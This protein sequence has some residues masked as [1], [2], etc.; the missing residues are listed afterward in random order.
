MK[1]YFFYGILVLL[2]SNCS[3]VEKHNAFIDSDLTIKQQ[4]KDIDYLEKKLK[5]IQPNLYA[6]LSKDALQRKF[7]SVRKTITI[8]LKPNEFYFKVFPLLNSVKQ[9]HNSVTNLSKRY[10]KKEVKEMKKKG[11]GPMSQF[12]LRWKDERLFVMKNNSKDSTLKK[13][14]EVL[15][16]DK[17]T[18]QDLFKKY[19][20][21]MTSDGFNTTWI[22][23]L[24]SKRLGGFYFNELGLRDSLSYV[25]KEKDSVFKKMIVR[26]AKE[27]KK[28]TIQNDSIQN[29]SLKMKKVLTKL[30]KK[31]AKKKRKAENKYKYNYGYDATTKDYSKVL[32]FTDIDSCSAVFKIKN[33]SKGSYK[34]AYKEVF[35]LLRTTD[36]KNLILDLRDNP[37]GRLD[38]IHKLYS[39]LTPNP[40]YQLIENARLTS[41]LSLLK[42]NYLKGMPK[43]FYLVTVPTYPIYAGIALLKTKKDDEG[44][45]FRMKSSKEKPNDPFHFKGKTYVMINGGSFSASCIL[46]SK[47]KQNTDIIFVG[48]ETGG[49]F[50]G[51]VAGRTALQELP[52]SKLNVRLW[53]MEIAAT[54]KTEVIGRGI[55]PDK[56]IIPTLEDVLNDNDPELEWIKADIESKKLPSKKPL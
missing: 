46:S 41:K 32:T 6:Y 40:T 13:G 20:Q 23:Y 31:A 21:N 55:F 54:N 36:T 34:V 1:N 18:P 25:F 11:K 29:D 50:N 7:D 28:E 27:E 56:E 47:L 39:Y 10:T 26:L 4:L 51:T 44:Y 49:D 22:P 5:N 12:D 35:E 43:L 53:I 3:S 48:E 8:P 30:E 37:G 52:N 2:L 42:V 45:Y 19:K 33:F 15:S 16:I 14:L 9:G 24:F 38:E 17:L